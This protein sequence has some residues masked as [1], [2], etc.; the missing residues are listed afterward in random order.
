MGQSKSTYLEY[1][2]QYI[3]VHIQVAKQLRFDLKFNLIC[4]TPH[5]DEF[6]SR[7]GAT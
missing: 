7:A 3:K 2:T 6:P 5:G 4:V 1:K